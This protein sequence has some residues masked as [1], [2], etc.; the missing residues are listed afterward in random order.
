ME[1]KPLAATKK[2]L[3]AALSEL[4]PEDMFNIIAFNGETFPFS[5]SMK[6]ANQET[7]DRAI[8]WMED[9]L[10]VGDGTNISLA[11]DK[12]VYFSQPNFYE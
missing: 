10:L 1:G 9:T 4:S 12:V 6:L 8:Q 7:I 2:S 3:S 11:L 5:S